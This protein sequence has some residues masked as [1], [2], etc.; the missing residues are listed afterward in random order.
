M[1]TM[2]F[3]AGLIVGAAGAILLCMM[4]FYLA[5]HY[6]DAEDYYNDYYD[7]EDY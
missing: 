1:N 4:L 6:K 7:Y 2:A 5:L 3:F